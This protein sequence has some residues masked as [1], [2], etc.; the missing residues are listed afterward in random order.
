[1]AH[2]KICFEGLGYSDIRTYINSG[3]VIFRCSA[4]DQRGLETSIEEALRTKFACKILVVVKSLAEVDS[5]VSQIPSSW[6]G[7]TDKKCN[8]IFLHHSIDNPNILKNFR[9]KPEIEQLHYHPG[10]LFWSAQISSL[11]KSSM[12]K[13]STLPLYKNMTVRILNTALKIQTIMQQT[14]KIAK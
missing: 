9:P 3:N 12:I 13:L 4:V 10:V 11:T 6:R 8:V 14:D 7:A 2:L 1:M 5:L